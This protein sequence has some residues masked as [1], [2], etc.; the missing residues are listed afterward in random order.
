MQL[1]KIRRANGKL[2]VGVLDG[3]S[4]RVLE[5]NKLD[6]PQT[7][8][9]VLYSSEPAE[10]V[11]TL[12]DRGAPA[13]ALDA[14]RFLPP[15]DNQEVW[16]A[17]VTYKRSK[18]A[19]E[20]ESVGAARFYDMVYT[21]Q[22]PELFFKAPA[23]R[24][25]GQGQ[26]VR[27]RRDARW[28]VPEPEVALVVSPALRIVGYTIGNDMSSRDIEGENP[29]YLPQAKFYDGSCA[30]GPVV[31]LAEQFGPPE[32]VS[33]QLTI[34]RSGSVAFAGS[35]GLDAMARTFVDLVSWLGRE[36]SFPEGVVLLTGTGIVPPDDFTLASGD[37]IVI[38]VTGIGRLANPVA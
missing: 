28:S 24:V 37:E 21:A 34:R 35:T 10:L 25:V 27:I 36:T 8:S 20:S 9:D 5:L 38:E 4:V 23:W 3:A 1:C 19:R 26:P 31:T 22:R 18:V 12:L 14:V 32:Q 7:L 29:L 33:I 13:L 11:R 2:E 6:G 16:A 17:G 15:L 30:V